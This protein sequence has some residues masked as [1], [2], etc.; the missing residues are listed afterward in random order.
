VITLPPD[1]TL[2]E[3]RE[4][5]SGCDDDVDLARA[6]LLIAKLDYPD[7]DLTSVLESLDAL[8]ARVVI[9]CAQDPDPLVQVDALTSVVLR[10][11]GLHGSQDGY[12]DPRYS[13]LNDVLES[14]V[15]I[16]VSLSVVFMSVG[17]RAGIALAGTAM[18]MHFLV[19]VLGVKPPV[20][21][22][23]YNGGR[24]LTYEE[25]K[26]ALRRMSTGHIA[27]RKEML[28]C[29]SNCAVISRML[30]NL[31]EIYMNSLPYAKVLPVLHRLILLNPDD[32]SLLRDRGFVRYRLGQ[33]PMARQDLKQYLSS[34][35]GAP[36]AEEVRNLLRRIG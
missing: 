2:D 14:R 32:T 26:E 28:D 25:C 5:I 20:F 29:V 1:S 34:T 8:A 24:L 13:F 10:D 21:V 12:S 11:L 17:A 22:D 3:F 27:F 31:R 33:G 7:L 9:R 18:P 30:A 4:A 23:C 19:R 15:G 36:D 6:A 35:R 16:P